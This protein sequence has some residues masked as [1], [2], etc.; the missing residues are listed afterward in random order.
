LKRILEETELK[1]EFSYIIIDQESENIL[2][3]MTDYFSKINDVAKEIESKLLQL[4]CK[5]HIEPHPLN[6]TR[7]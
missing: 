6:N 7:R 4:Y 5:D 1:L 3:L 2:K